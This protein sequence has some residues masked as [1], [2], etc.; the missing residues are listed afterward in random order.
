MVE[1]HHQLVEDRIQYITV[2]TLGDAIDFGDTTHSWYAGFGFSNT[3]RG[4][5]GG[6]IQIH[7]II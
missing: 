1:I 7:Q 4:I 2:D 3:V 5:A 6:G